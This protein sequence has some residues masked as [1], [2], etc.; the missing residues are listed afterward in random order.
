MA[1]VDE[2]KT[3]GR[4]P[5]YCPECG[6]PVTVEHYCP[7]C[8]HELDIATNTFEVAGDQTQVLPPR[9]PA[10]RPLD[11][12]PG[13]ERPRRRA[14]L[15]ALPMV[16]VIAAAAAVAIILLSN[17]NSTQSSSLSYRQK[18]TSALAPVMVANRSLSGGLQSLDGSRKTI[19]AA[20]SATARAQSA[21]VS[22]QGAIAV[23]TVPSSNTT[24]SQ[25]VQ[26]AL[27]D[28]SGYLQ[29]VSSTL[30]NPGSQSASQLQTLVTATQSALV[31]LAPVAAGAA[32]SLN[33]TGN[34]LSWAGGATAKAQ[35]RTQAAQRK[36]TQPQ[37]PSG[38]TTSPPQTPS[39]PSG[40]TACD[41]NISV[42]SNTSCPFADNV[43]AQYAQDV[44]Q[45]GAPG[46]D[47]VYAYSPA[48]GQSYPETCNYN[49]ANQIVLCSHGSD[50]IQFP[51]WAA[52]VYRQ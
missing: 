35:R 10:G 41:Q 46:S 13:G 47:V 37:S 17:S 21:V 38:T 3:G 9:P 28:E 30:A 48:T 11:G 25:Q 27:T 5:H 12:E 29:A 45:A 24:L 2:T 14:L 51:Y 7:D 49:P 40:L 20:R 6:H 16:L 52:E 44:Q 43:F 8:G 42:N 39:A 4:Q 36:R 1:V 32:S 23:L 18:L 34:L 22:A 15:I 19:S 26:Q 31:P 33:G 50:L